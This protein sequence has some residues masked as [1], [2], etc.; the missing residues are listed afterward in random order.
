MDLDPT[1]EQIQEALEEFNSQ[2]PEIAEIARQGEIRQMEKENKQRWNEVQGPT[3]A[4][5]YGMTTLGIGSQLALAGVVLTSPIGAILGLGMVAGGAA[6]T[7][8]VGIH[9]AVAWWRNRK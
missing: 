6:G 9:Q 2:F 8:V 1:E 4:F 5:M 3:L 7:T